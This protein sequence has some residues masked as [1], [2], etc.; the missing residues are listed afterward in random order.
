MSRAIVAHAHLETAVPDAAPDPDRAALG[1]GR[2]GVMHGVLDE[3]LDG[4]RRDIELGGLGG[5]IQMNGESVLEAQL[6]ER[7]ILTRE[8]VLLGKFD[9]TTPVLLERVTQHVTETL[10]GVFCQRR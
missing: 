10:D 1:A 7:E 2:D 6:F 4:E 5:N 3:R 9:E 8:L